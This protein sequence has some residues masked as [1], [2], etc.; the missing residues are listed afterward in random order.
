MASYAI[1][2][3]SASSGGSYSLVAVFIVAVGISLGA[4]SLNLIP[5]NPPNLVHNW[6]LICGYCLVSIVVLAVWCFLA[7]HAPPT[8]TEVV[9]Q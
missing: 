7:K 8:T 1:N 3:L 2:C 9:K 6:E 4:Q 5:S